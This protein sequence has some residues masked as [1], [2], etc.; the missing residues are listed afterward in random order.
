MASLRLQPRKIESRR[1]DES[2]LPILQD[3]SFIYYGC[4][5]GTL[6]LTQARNALYSELQLH[7]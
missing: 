6:S 3:E 5:N 1:L 7:F 2:L 4:W